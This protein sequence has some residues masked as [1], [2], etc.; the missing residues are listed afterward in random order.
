METEVRGCQEL[1]KDIPASCR[2]GATGNCYAAVRQC[3]PDAAMR[4]FYPHNPLE[5]RKEQQ[6]LF[7]GIVRGNRVYASHPLSDLIPGQMHCPLHALVYPV[8]GNTS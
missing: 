5:G 2:I 3:S 4:E 6:G 7:L 1:A 8:T